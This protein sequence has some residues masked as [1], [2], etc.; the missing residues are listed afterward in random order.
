MICIHQKD[1]QGAES[2]GALAVRD[3][4]GSQRIWGE[5]RIFG[6]KNGTNELN[7]INFLFEFAK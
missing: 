2:S 4:G 1:C 3:C 7:L 6:V 5:K